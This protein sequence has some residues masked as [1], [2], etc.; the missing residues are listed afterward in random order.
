MVNLWCLILCDEMYLLFK[1]K[2]IL[3]NSFHPAKQ[4]ACPVGRQ[5]I[6]FSIRLYPK[7]KPVDRHPE[8]FY[9]SK[10]NGII[11][12]NTYRTNLWK[13]VHRLQIPGRAVL[14]LYEN[15]NV[16]F[17]KKQKLFQI[18]FTKGIIKFLQYKLPLEMWYATDSFVLQRKSFIVRRMQNIF[19][20]KR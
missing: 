19:F 13:P 14:F 2:M 20:K 1:N 9:K 5:I 4:P 16:A 15:Y 3:H 8:L 12:H 17:K 6:R 11:Y 18:D 7:R 10:N